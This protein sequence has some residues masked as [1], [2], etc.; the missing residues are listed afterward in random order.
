MIEKFATVHML[1]VHIRTTDGRE[2]I[3]ARYPQPGPEL[4]LPQ[5]LALDLPAPTAAE[6]QHRRR[7]VSQG[8]V[9]QTYGDPF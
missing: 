6:D 7:D 2:L 5:K 4:M 1:D 3:L 8:R 9:L